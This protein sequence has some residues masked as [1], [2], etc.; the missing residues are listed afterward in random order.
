[1]SY[2]R[3][4]LRNVYSKFHELSDRSPW[5]GTERQRNDPGGL[6]R[7]DPP[8]QACRHE[9]HG[10]CGKEYQ[11]KRYNDGKGLYECPYGRYGAWLLYQF[12]AAPSG[13][14]P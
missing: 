8:C 12:H 14:C 1:M 2:L 6:F 13:D 5:H 7:E 9:D 4:L 11:A 3:F 10:A